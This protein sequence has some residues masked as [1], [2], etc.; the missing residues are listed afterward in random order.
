MLTPYELVASPEWIEAAGRPD[1]AE[2]LAGLSGIGWWQVGTAPRW[3]LISVDGQEHQV[4]IRPRFQTNNLAV[5]RL[6]ALEGLGMARLPRPLCQQ[7]M[8]DGRLQRVIPDLAPDPMGIHV[9]YP[10]RRSLTPAGR[11]FLELVEEALAAFRRENE[12]SHQAWL[13]YERSTEE[14]FGGAAALT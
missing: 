13:A 3:R 11:Q 9:I 12:V 6:A 14:R 2:A 5:V 1:C 7:D 8:H 10:T 4:P